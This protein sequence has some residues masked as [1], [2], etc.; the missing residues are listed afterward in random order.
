[1][2]L[3]TD[4]KKANKLPAATP[5]PLATATDPIQVAAQEPAAI[6]AL[7]KPTAARAAGIP[8]EA[9]TAHGQEET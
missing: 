2:P 9:P 7:V 3:P 4:C 6:P 5:P 1:M 8:T